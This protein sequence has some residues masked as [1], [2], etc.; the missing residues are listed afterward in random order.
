LFPSQRP[1]GAETPAEE[2]LGGAVAGVDELNV[3]LD[4]FVVSPL[5]P[6]FLAK[7]NLLERL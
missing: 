4:T 6:H 5:R 7:E 1:T 2:T 3:F